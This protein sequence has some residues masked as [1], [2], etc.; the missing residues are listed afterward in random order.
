[1]MTRM[2]QL[3]GSIEGI[4]QSK[5]G[6]I[7]Y[8]HD[9]HIELDIYESIYNVTIYKSLTLQMDSRGSLNSFAVLQFSKLYKFIF[10]IVIFHCQSDTNK[11]DQL[12]C[13]HF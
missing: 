2:M 6:K 5:N 4:I 11:N 8:G 12:F 10:K 3:G 1:M 7:G 9:K 13:G